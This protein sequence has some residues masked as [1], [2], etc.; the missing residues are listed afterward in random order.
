MI[1]NYE[2]I[3][4][5]ITYCLNN[6]NRHF[7]I[8]E[9]ATFM[10]L[11]P[12]SLQSAFVEWSGVNFD[13]FVNY[14]SVKTLK[15]EI[16]YSSALIKTDKI[17]NPLYRVSNSYFN[18]KVI[19]H[20]TPECTIKNISY[21]LTESPFGKC[22]VAVSPYGICNLLFVDSDEDIA[23]SIIYLSKKW[24]QAQLQQDKDIAVSVINNLFSNEHHEFHL[25]LKGTPF[26]VSVWKALLSV[27]FGK[28]IT[29]SMLA[30]ILNRPKAVRAV[31]SAVGN[32]PISLLLPCH[33]IIRSEGLIGQYH[34]HNAR[35]ACIIGWEKAQSR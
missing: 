11:S 1:A 26:Q 8:K 13:R 22:L 27:S 12:N 20:T 7:S 30:S 16:K 29:Y 32:N 21:G 18:A 15:E 33:R 6:H 9:I 34:W 17:K 23:T 24:P 3:Q 4:E 28:V 35:K 10:E 25:Y 19:I 2:R 31:A 14:L 5:A